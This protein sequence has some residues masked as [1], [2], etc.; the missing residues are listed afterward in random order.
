MRT[1]AREEKGRKVED[2]ALR[3]TK[4][5]DEGEEEEE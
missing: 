1:S 3:T 2:G 4:G 5:K